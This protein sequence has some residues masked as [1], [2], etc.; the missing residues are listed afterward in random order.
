MAARWRGA[1]SC[2]QDGLGAARG[3]VVW[4]LPGLAIWIV[5]ALV[6]WVVI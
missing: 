6:V 4:I 2:R 3:L 1:D 5:V